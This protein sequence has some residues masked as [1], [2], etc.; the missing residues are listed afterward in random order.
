MVMRQILNQIA[1][2]FET[3]VCPT[4]TDAAFSAA[5]LKWLDRVHENGEPWS[6][7][8]RANTLGHLRLAL[9]AASNHPDHGFVAQHV[10]DVL[11][12]NPWPGRHIK[13][14]PTEVLNPEA[15]LAVIRACLAEVEGIRRRLE[16]RDV[17]LDAGLAVVDAAQH[18]GDPIDFSDINVCVAV[19]AQLE[20]TSGRLMSLKDIF[21]CDRSLGSAVKQTHGLSEV[22]KT[23]HA[24][25]RSLVPFVLLISIASAFNPD[26]ALA[27]EWRNIKPCFNG[28]HVSI[29]GSKGRSPSAQTSRV[30]TNED[31]QEGD[32]GAGDRLLAAEPGQ[33]GGITDLLDLLRRLTSRTRYLV[34][35]AFTDRLF[36][37]VPLTSASIA[38]AFESR[39]GPSA[40][41]T[42]RNALASFIADHRLPPFTLKVIRA[43][44]YEIEY[45]RTGSLSAASAR[46]SHASVDTGQR[47]YTSDWVR[48]DGQA[49]IAGVQELLLRWAG[50]E[51]TIDPR[52]LPHPEDAP[53]ATPGFSC[54][55]PRASPIPGQRHGR[56]CTAYG[57][58]PACPLMAARPQDFASAAY[59]LA[60]RDAIARGRTGVTDAGPWVE[61]WGPVLRD[62]D[63]L[64]AEIPVNVRRKA[65]QIRVSLQPVA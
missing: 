47:H 4:D 53:A 16:E 39:R 64:I 29:T 8:T 10:L 9:I 5:L 63:T 28:T 59:Y 25:F 61:E 56:L 20:Q 34:D 24:T 41:L 51:G 31:D 50:T 27:L 3:A 22:R 43:T 21:A 54:L 33:T 40:D 57:K 1:P 60:L 36:V 35:E 42:W 7:N 46:L 6:V 13:I 38:S 62:L 32:A 52:G 12:V 37:G 14:R 48:R 55:D 49:K 23:V 26:T 2:F 45:R 17:A 65:A 44:E 58:C 19:V 11:P 15:R 30:S 18:V